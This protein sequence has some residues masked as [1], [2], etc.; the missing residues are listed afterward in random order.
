MANKYTKKCPISLHIKEMQLKST[1]RFHLISVRMPTTKQQQLLVGM[2]ISPAT[3]EIS[4]LKIDLSYD[5]LDH[6]WAYTQ[7]NGSQHT[8]EKPAH[9]YL[10]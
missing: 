2:S 5:E 7:W 10:L 6:P 9:P 8:V 4:I 1:L 3:V